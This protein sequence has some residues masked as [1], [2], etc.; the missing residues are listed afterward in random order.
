MADLWVGL[1]LKASEVAESETGFLA[2][3]YLLPGGANFLCTVGAHGSSLAQSSAT[4]QRGSA[5]SS[6]GDP[7]GPRWWERAR[8]W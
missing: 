6:D 5:N 7:R 1:V 2:V 8:R 3:R 4:S